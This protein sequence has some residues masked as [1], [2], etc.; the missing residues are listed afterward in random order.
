M[1]EVAVGESH[2]SAAHTL[3]SSQNPKE[4]ILVGSFQPQKFHEPFKLNTLLSP[5]NIEAITKLRLLFSFCDS[6]WSHTSLFISVLATDHSLL[7]DLSKIDSLSK[8]QM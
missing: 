7:P 1:K 2:R 3:Q 8:P 4:L 6:I 5:I